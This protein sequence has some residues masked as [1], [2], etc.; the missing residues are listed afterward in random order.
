MSIYE[1][2]FDE[3][4]D[5]MKEQLHIIHNAGKTV[6][7]YKHKQR[8]REAIKKAGSMGGDQCMSCTSTAIIREELGL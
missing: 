6:G 3:C 7:V 4:I 1:H 8:V 2:P 5:V